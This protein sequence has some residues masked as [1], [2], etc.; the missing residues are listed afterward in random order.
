MRRDRAVVDDAAAA[1]RLV[2]HDAEGMLGAQERRGE[3]GVHHGLPLGD[4]DVLERHRRCADAGIV[5]HEVEPAE[6]V[7]H[8]GEQ[9][10]DRAG[11]GHVGG[12]RQALAEGFAELG[13]FFQLVGAAAGERHRVA[14]L[15]QRERRCSSDA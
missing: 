4:A 10:G 11:I 9:R 15:H 3:V 7:G 2:L 1:R 13:G 5:E 12:H 8:L 6:A 14:G